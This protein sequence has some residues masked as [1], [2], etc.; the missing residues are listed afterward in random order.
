M[1][2][3]FNELLQRSSIMNTCRLLHA[4]IVL[5]VGVGLVSCAIDAERS[6]YD[7]ASAG[8]SVIEPLPAR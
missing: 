1:D 7:P 3:Q 4:C 6:G 2:K 8:Q 5:A